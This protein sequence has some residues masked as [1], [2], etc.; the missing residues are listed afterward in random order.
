MH[1]P[2]RGRTPRGS[3]ANRTNGERNRSAQEAEQGGPRQGAIVLV[4]NMTPQINQ[5]IG[6]LAYID[7]LD[8]RQI[9]NHTWSAQLVPFI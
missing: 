4:P 5:L 8:N 2:V 6:S 1:G 7:S 3:G 9:G